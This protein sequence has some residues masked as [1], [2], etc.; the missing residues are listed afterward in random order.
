M[1]VIPLIDA[2]GLPGAVAVDAAWLGNGSA[3]GSVSQANNMQCTELLV[4]TPERE[5]ADLPLVLGS[6]GACAA[7]E[8][9][10]SYARG[11]DVLWSRLQGAT[12]EWMSKN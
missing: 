8:Q 5:A 1:V 4:R 10:G 9:C 12:T 6:D 2:N 3:Y 11:L 7:A